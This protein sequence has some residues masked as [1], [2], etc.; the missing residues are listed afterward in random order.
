MY[1][2]YAGETS[3]F[4]S[5]RTLIYKVCCEFENARALCEPKHRAVSCQACADHCL[6]DESSLLLLQP[7]P[8]LPGAAASHDVTALLVSELTR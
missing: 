3:L 7:Q 5:S 1:D 8:E 2:I 6:R 4:S